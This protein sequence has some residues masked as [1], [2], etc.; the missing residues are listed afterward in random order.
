METFVDFS[1]D[2]RV[3]MR[4]YVMGDSRHDRWAEKRALSTMSRRRSRRVHGGCARTQLL[5][6]TRPYS[7]LAFTQ[8]STMSLLRACPKRAFKPLAIAVRHE[9]TTAFNA[10]LVKERPAAEVAPIPV[11]KDIVAA[12]EVSGA[13]GAFTFIFVTV[14]ITDNVI[15][16]LR[17]RTVRIFQPT[18]N[19]MQSGGAKGEKWR[20][21]WD[22]LPGGGRWENSLM[23]WASSY[24]YLY[25]LIILYSSWCRADYMQGT[26][27][28]FRTKEEAIAFAERQGM[29]HLFYFT[30]FTYKF[31]ACLNV[32][33]DYFMYVLTLPPVQSIAYLVPAN[34][35]PSRKSRRRT[36]PR[37]MSTSPISFVFAG[38]SNGTLYTASSFN[39]HISISFLERWH[40]TI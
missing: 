39:R 21:D 14:L 2:F 7:S 11:E 25:I 18:R 35:L 13:P 33:W 40:R 6:P 9:N 32:G 37:T 26:R 29:P 4:M 5:D 12:D 27:Q 10:A 22:I 31:S 34:L 8:H 30:N 20:L 3:I 15:A 36:T 24:V 19:T 17:H 1:L 28:S 38:R 23:G 16:E